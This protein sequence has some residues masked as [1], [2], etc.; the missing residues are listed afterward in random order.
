MRRENFSS[1]WGTSSE[2]SSTAG[3]GCVQGA[4]TG[5]EE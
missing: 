5:K 4:E 3:L 1:D 2:Q